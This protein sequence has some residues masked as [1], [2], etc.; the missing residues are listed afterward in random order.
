ML[1]SYTNRNCSEAKLFLYF[2]GFLKNGINS[3][4]CKD[5]SVLF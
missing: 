1:E 5:K 3:N 2:S 4:D